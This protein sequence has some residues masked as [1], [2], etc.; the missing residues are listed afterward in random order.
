MVSFAD[1]NWITEGVN[2]Y[3]YRP[4]IGP[5]GQMVI[6]ER[7]YFNS[8]TN[9]TLYRMLGLNDKD[10]T[11]FVPG[12]INALTRPDWCWKQ[13]KIAYNSA[14]T[15]KD[16]HTVWQ[17]NDDGFNPSEVPR[18]VGYIYPQWNVDGSNVTV[19]N[20]NSDYA[21]P[22]PCST[23]IH[24]NGDIIYPNLNGSDEDGTPLFGGMPAVNPQN[25]LS[26]AFAGQ[27]TDW[28]TEQDV[29]TYNQDLNYIFLNSQAKHSFTSSPMEQGAPINSY[30]P[31]FQGR[32]PA[33]SPDG[34]YIV[35]ESN[36]GD[37]T[38]ELYALYLFDTQGNG[39]SPQPLTDTKYNA[40]HAK[41][42]PNGTMLIFAG[43]PTSK[44]G[45]RIGWIDIS[46]QIANADHLSSRR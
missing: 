46:Q 44:S 14:K 17:I 28:S 23:M 4:A 3:D 40:Q 21:K 24:T 32:A 1:I 30:D 10:P 20:K 38:G 41:F 26:I 13:H 29:A 18:T 45:F 37:S 8:S 25:E 27:P 36:R 42:F 2:F 12:N 33:W 43:K 5:D 9:V 31:G 19:M 35:F 6:F 15:E 7:T 22:N 39:A 16:V 34:R 11:P